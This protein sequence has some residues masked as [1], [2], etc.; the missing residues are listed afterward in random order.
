MSIIKLGV[1][2]L[3]IMVFLMASQIMAY[4]AGSDDAGHGHQ[5]DSKM[6]MQEV[7]QGLDVEMKNLTGAIIIEDYALIE[8]SARGIAQ[9]PSPSGAELERIFSILGEDSN[10]FKSCDQA[11]HDLAV[12]LAR[13]AERKNMKLILNIYDAMIAKTVEC[14]ARFKDRVASQK[15]D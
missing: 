9:H 15:P 11:V 7:M 5:G 1:M 12:K 10:E 4:A 14:H 3:A 2:S 8:Q 6:S 13:A